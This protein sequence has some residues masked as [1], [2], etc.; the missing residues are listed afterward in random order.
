MSSESGAPRV[1]LQR[2]IRRTGMGRE[3]TRRDNELT[4][5]KAIVGNDLSCL[6]FLFASNRV[7]V[8]PWALQDA[9]IAGGFAREN[10]RVPLGCP[11]SSL[12]ASEFARPGWQGRTCPAN[13]T[14]RGLAELSERILG[15]AFLVF[16]H[17]ALLR[18]ALPLAEFCELPL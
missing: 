1:P 10:G 6:R 5:I 2:G 8:P 11:F 15:T 9:E 18:L 12:R 13:G 16:R 4:K 3:G 14:R 7:R 17:S